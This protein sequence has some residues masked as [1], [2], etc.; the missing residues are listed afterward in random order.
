M[1]SMTHGARVN[2]R[3]LQLFTITLVSDVKTERRYRLNYSS[4]VIRNRDQ[5]RYESCG[6]NV[7]WRLTL[8]P[9]SLRL[10][11]DRFIRKT[12]I[13]FHMVHTPHSCAGCVCNTSILIIINNASYRLR[14][15]NPAIRLIV[16]FVTSKGCFRSRISSCNHSITNLIRLVRDAI[17]FLISWRLMSK[18]KISFL[19]T[20]LA[21]YLPG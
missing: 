12:D 11:Y 9:F 8:S 6:S 19:R 18:R 17:Q 10:S 7:T 1:E 21:G 3:S 16:T 13:C 20:L 15:W 5:F 4:Y 2:S 14:S